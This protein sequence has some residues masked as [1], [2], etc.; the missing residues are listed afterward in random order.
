[1]AACFPATG[2]H[3]QA[4]C[5]NPRQA[6]MNISDG[7]LAEYAGKL[8]PF[9]NQIPDYALFMLDTSGR[10]ISWN[11]GAQKLK[12]YTAQEII[13]RNFSVFYSAEDV[14]MDKP[15]HALDIASR[16]GTYQEEGMRIRKDGTSFCATVTITP[17]KD[18]EG[19][20]CGFAKLTRDITARKTHDAA[21]LEASEA[22]Y[23]AL[24]EN[25]HDAI[26]LTRPADGAV[27]AANTAACRL[28][29][30]PDQE[31]LSMHRDDLLD[32]SD[33]R[34]VKAWEE[35]AAVGSAA[36]ELTFIRKDGTRFE[37]RASSKL[38]ADENGSQLACTGIHDITERK[39]AEDA[40]RRSEEKFRLLYENAPVGIIQIDQNGYVTSANQKFAEISGYSPEEAVG[41]DYMSVTLPEDRVRIGK[42]VEQLLSGEIDTSQNENCLLRKDKSTVQV[43]VVAGLVRD[44]QGMFQSGIV[45]FEDIS[46]RKQAEE[47]LRQS[48]EKFRAT[49]ENAPIG[50]AECTLEGRFLKVNSKLVEILGYTKDELLQL[51]TLDVTHPGDLEKT[52]ADLKRLAAGETS[53]NFLEKR[54]L[55]KDHSFVW[56]NVTASCTSIRGKAPYMVVTVEDITA[57]KKAE[58]D[59]KR[60]IE[61]SYH[62]ANH[63]MLTGLANRTSFNDR[64]D[65]ALDYAKRDGH[66]VAIHLLDL[67][68]FKSVNDTLGHH[69][70]DLL[71]KE[72]AKRITSN[73]RSTDL[74][75]RLGGDEFVVI[76]THMAEPAAAAV[77]AAKLVEDLGRTYLLEGQNVH[78]GTSIGIAVYPGDACDLEELMKHADLALYEAKRL[79]RFNYQ[80]YRQELGAAFREAQRLEQELLTALREEQFF[81]HYQ[82]QF[83]VQS[84]RITGIETL[85]RWRHPERGILPA[86]AFIQSAERAKLMPSIGEWTF[87]TA[88]RQYKEWIDSGFA[89]PLTL[90]LSAM[91]LR[92]PGF[93][94]TLG[95]ILEET[96][97][98]ASSLLLEMREGV[99]RDPK[100][101]KKLLDQMNEAGLHL[102]LED[103]CADMVALSTLDR[104]PLAAVKPGQGLM[105][106]LPSRQRRAT[107]L[108]AIINI[109]HNLKIVVCAD[110][111]ETTDQF[112]AAK[113]Q[114][115]DSAQGFLLSSPL[116][117]AEMTRLIEVELT[118][119]TPPPPAAAR[120][121]PH[122]H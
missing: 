87:R 31:L 77:M 54:Y 70:G 64:F 100:L 27:L 55:R 29:G 5:F 1:M 86:A 23:R 75:A 58:E 44:D 13:G 14:A 25:S 82:P 38:F 45:A 93:L 107:I 83:D 65:E 102:A 115:C 109:A 118:P 51:A 90:N 85:L 101:S 11:A 36:A 41:F 60:A 76:Q 91:Q 99:L 97:V 12:G 10:V 119:R 53:N 3:E 120:I 73:I 52:I 114:G 92:D 88:C 67:D 46:A 19:R 121:Q 4:S 26:L 48:E 62:Q 24:Y 6:A 49:F 80:F 39:Q 72:V 89:A 7:A 106:E 32:S 43:N 28:F 17:L 103:F 56:V 30:Y 108:T 69:V 111:I 34:F 42:I 50:I 98:P 16:E 116:D 96:G 57:R 21:L 79:G 74:A 59:L 22:R 61:A 8:E 78:S 20:L 113:E 104:F 71:L 84:G 94:Q 15:H 47:A 35:R 110:G 95:Q 37:A 2:R 63:D 40:L 117:A 33:P 66:T 9:I 68:S 105:R 81:L 112:A 122:A 18:E